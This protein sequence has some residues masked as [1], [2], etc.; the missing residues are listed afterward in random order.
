MLVHFPVACWSLGTFCDGLTVAGYPRAWPEGALLLTIGLALALP[1]ALA[2]FIDFIALPEKSIHTGTVHMM[3][4]G[5]A[6]CLYLIT[7]LL[8][9][10]GWALAAKPG[11]ATVTLS[12]LGL[13]I[14]VAGGH[15]GGQL[16]YRFGAGVNQNRPEC[17]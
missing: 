14:M 3:L 5:T 16:V 10:D 6:W 1:A 9:S 4:M 13:L 12:F 15:Y 2:G 8:R 17:R 11:W 7:M